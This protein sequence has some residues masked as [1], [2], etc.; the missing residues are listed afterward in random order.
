MVRRL[1]SQRDGKLPSNE[2]NYVRVVDKLPKMPLSEIVF[3]TYDAKTQSG[4]NYWRWT[5]DGWEPDK[6]GTTV[7]SNRLE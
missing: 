7:P 2:E 5:G 4:G 6:S 3:L 1:Q